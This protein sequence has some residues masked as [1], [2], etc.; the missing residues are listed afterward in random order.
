MIMMMLVV[1]V[2]LCVDDV[3]DDVVVVDLVVVVSVAEFRILHG[4]SKQSKYDAGCVVL[5]KC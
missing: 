1:A 4:Y 3:V 2:F 5:C